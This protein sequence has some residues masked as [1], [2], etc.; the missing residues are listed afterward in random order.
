MAVVWIGAVFHE[1]EKI[2]LPPATIAV[3]VPVFPPLQ[4][5]FTCEVVTAILFDGAVISTLAVCDTVHPLLS[6]T[7]T[8][9]PPIASPVAVAVVC[10]LVHE[11][12]NVPLPPAT[13]AVALPVFPPLQ[14]TFT[15]DVVTAI[16]FDGAVI[17]TLALCD[18]VHPLLSVTVTVYVPGVADKPVA[19]CVLCAGVVFHTYVNTPL[20]PA[21]IAV[22]LPVFP[23]LQNT[24]TC[25]VV[26]A[27]LLDGAVINT[28]AFCDTVHPLLS[29]TVTV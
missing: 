8:T 2:P 23:P 11:Y 26:T 21:T 13:I 9:Y 15:C 18:T 14:N 16:L 28:L 27:I 20:P 10:P 19:V 6:V 22:A 5:T 25:E 17:N 12:V 7:V 4:N 3:A 24:F 29:V 1:Y